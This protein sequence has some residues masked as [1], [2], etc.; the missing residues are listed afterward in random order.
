MT[1]DFLVTLVVGKLRPISVVSYTVKDAVSVYSVNH[2]CQRR[3]VRVERCVA[4]GAAT[5]AAHITQVHSRVMDG[6]VLQL[7]R[8]LLLHISSRAEVVVVLLL[9]LLNV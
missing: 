8:T 5:S 7:F 9:K 4:A 2:A 3:L 6:S 1:C